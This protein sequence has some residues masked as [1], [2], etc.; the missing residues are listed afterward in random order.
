MAS[1]RRPSVANLDEA[2]R[3]RP[4]GEVLADLPWDAE[5]DATPDPQKLSALEFF[6]KLAQR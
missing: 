1:E 3:A 6:K 4:T 2:S 5:H